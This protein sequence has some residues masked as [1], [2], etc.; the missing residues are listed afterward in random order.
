MKHD[1]VNLIGSKFGNWTVL[2][3]AK[4][5]VYKN[6]YYLC[7]C[8]C[9]NEEIVRYSTLKNGESKS[10]GCLAKK[11]SSIKNRKNQGERAFNT[12]YYMYSYEAK[13]RGLVFEINKEKFREITSADCNYCGAKPSN[14]LND[15]RLKYGLY[16]YNGIDRVDNTKG[17]IEGNIVTC[18]AQCNRMKLDLTLEE[19]KNK[20]YLIYN[21]FFNK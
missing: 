16:F 2:S 17:Y 9:G 7:R 13:S 5:T 1:G 6:A 3:L 15:K 19:F 20:I 10:C 21:R 4:R 12:T 11:L 8:S 18:C 14:F